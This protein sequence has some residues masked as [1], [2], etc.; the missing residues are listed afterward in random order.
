MDD[1]KSTKDQLLPDGN[2]ECQH[3]LNKHLPLV[4]L[5][6]QEGNLLQLNR[7][8]T[9]RK[10]I[11]FYSLTGDPNKKL[12]KNWN[13]IPGASGCSLENII[14]R[15]NYENLIKLNALPIGIS[16]QSILDINE[17]TQ[18]IGI[19]YD[20]LSDSDLIFA[21][22]LSLPVFS[23]D[24]RNFIRRLTIIVEKNIIKKVFYP[25]V[26]INKHVDNVLKWLKEN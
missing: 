23:V 25:I 5:P 2:R 4:S 16:A 3:L 22:K 8:D 17:M 13:K 15:D 21:Q 26:S 12:P 18:R 24:N 14:F 10:V 7:E 1:T 6:N 19:Q 20:I 9:F 11:Y